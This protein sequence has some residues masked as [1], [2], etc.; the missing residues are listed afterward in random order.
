MILSKSFSE[1]T[2][3]RVADLL[4]NI[5]DLV[6]KIVADDSVRLRMILEDISCRSYM[7]VLALLKVC[8][9]RL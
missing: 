3:A 4:L 8:L 2:L 7:L 1:R 6:P 9:L 5:R